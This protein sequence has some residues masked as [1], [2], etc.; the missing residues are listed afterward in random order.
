MS[1]IVED[2]EQRYRSA[3]AESLAKQ[4]E[5]RTTRIERHYANR[6]LNTS[7]LRR[8]KLRLMKRQHLNRIRQTILGSRNLYLAA[9]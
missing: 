9:G 6:M 4:L 7:L 3:N 5:R 8:L 2:G 1:K